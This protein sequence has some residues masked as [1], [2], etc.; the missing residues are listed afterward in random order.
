MAGARAVGHGPQPQAQGVGSWP[1]KPIRLIVPY[2]PAELAASLAA[3]S[4]V[5]G[6]VAKRINLTME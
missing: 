4:K 3:R 5:W 1:D 6:E 2:P